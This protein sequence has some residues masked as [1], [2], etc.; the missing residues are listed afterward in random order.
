MKTSETV[1]IVKEAP[2]IIHVWDDD[3]Q[4]NT[5]ETISVWDASETIGVL[6][7]DRQGNTPQMIG[8]WDDDDDNNNAQR[9]I[10][11]RTLPKCFPVPQ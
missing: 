8:V 10:E 1:M 6:D 11:E 9:N 4:R 7:D 2:E 5:S 3:G